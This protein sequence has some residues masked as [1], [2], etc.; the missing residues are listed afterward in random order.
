MPTETVQSAPAE[1]RDLRKVRN[2]VGCGR[3]LI[4][5]PVLTCSKCGHQLRLRCFAYQAERERYIAE[6]ID[7][8]ILAEGKTRRE[9]IGG[10][11]E[12]LYGY[13]NAVIDG[14]DTDGLIPRP[15]PLSHRLHYHFESLK[16]RI[17]GMFDDNHP[18]SIIACRYEVQEGH[19][20]HC[21]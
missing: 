17:R 11:Q 10:L 3:P 12:A 1:T 18:R 19:L 15:A 14:Q 13:F 20:Q 9:A 21:Q 8:D 6:C 7:L 2:C 16:D 4:V 5:E